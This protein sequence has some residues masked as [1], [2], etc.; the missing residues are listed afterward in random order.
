MKTNS[1]P[2]KNS[3]VISEVYSFFVVVV[4]KT[5]TGSSCP[6][7]LCPIASVLVICFCCTLI[8]K[9][10]CSVS[11]TINFIVTAGKS[12]FLKRDPC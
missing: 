5:G 3:F 4:I 12:C 1:L 10:N 2:F 7:N 9:N 11:D 6:Q 8:I